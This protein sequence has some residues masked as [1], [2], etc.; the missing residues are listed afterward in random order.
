[1]PSSNNCPTALR[2][3]SKGAPHPRPAAPPIAGSNLVLLVLQTRHALAQTFAQVSICGQEFLWRLC[4]GIDFITL[5]HE[6]WVG[7]IRH[8]VQLGHSSSLSPP[9]NQPVIFS[10]S[11]SSL[12]PASYFG[13]QVVASVFLD[14]KASPLTLKSAGQK[15]PN[16]FLERSEL[17][18]TYA[19]KLPV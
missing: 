2:S 14:E 18:A 9:G 3:A 1:V 15:T 6:E 5:P 10:N 12:P 13:P 17:F 4:F 11:L 19:S 16:S 7:G 8:S